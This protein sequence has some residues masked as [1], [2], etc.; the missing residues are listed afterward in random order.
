MPVITVD[1]LT[2][3]SLEQKRALVSKV[4][5]AV[6]ETLDVKPETVRMRI[7]ETDRSNSAQGGVL[8]SDMT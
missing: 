6:V 2:G 3:R 7:R 8:R 5:E 1:I 4:T